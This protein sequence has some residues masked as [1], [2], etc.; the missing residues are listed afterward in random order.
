[1]VE[2]GKNAGLSRRDLLLDLAQV[3]G[4]Y[5]PQFYE[6]QPDGSVKPN[7]PE[8]PERIL[9]RVATPIPAYSIGLPYVETVHDRLTIEIRRGCTRGCRFCQPGM[10]TR[11]ARDVEPEAVI[12]AIETGMRSTGYDAEYLITI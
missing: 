8:V 6:M 1:M 12:N 5:V 3:P 11:P 9:R 10:L 7:H 4:V 2:D